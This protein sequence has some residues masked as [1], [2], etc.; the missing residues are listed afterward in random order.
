MTTRLPILNLHGWILIILM[1]AV[2]ALRFYHLPQYPYH[3]DE[4]GSLNVMM[5]IVETGKPLLESGQIYWRAL[6]AH[7]LMAL[8]LFFLEISP[9][10]ARLIPVL[11][12][13]LVLP[14]A[15]LMG[16]DAESRWTGY[17]AALFL[18]LSSYENIHSAF[19]RFYLPFQFFF[20][21]SVYFSGSFF[22]DQ[23]K[24]TGK[25]LLFTTLATIGSHKLSFQL[26]PIMIFA[27]LMGRRWR[28]ISS[29]T[30]WVSI[31]VTGVAYYLVIFFQPENIYIASMAIPLITGDMANKSFY[32]DIFKYFF[33]F[34]TTLIILGLVPLCQNRS[35]SYV[36]YYV[37]FVFSMI[38]I[39]LLSPSGS[40]RYIAQL[41][42]IGVIL[43][44][45]SLVWWLKIAPHIAKK[46]HSL[47][48]PYRLAGAALVLLL[49]GVF[50]FSM[51]R[52]SIGTAFGFPVTRD[53]QKPAHDFIYSR[54]KAGDIIIS[55]EP[56][57]TK[58]Y[59]R[60]PA[61]Y[62]IREKF[63]NKIH[64]WR[65]FTDDEKGGGTV[66][67]SPDSLLKA[68]TDAADHRVWIY[69]N[70]KHE[71]TLSS[72][73]KKTIRKHFRTVYDERE[74]YVFLKD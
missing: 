55:M 32:L 17:M 34:G 51:E 25:Y 31:V 61:D 40:A 57:L 38:V 29:K 6:V 16:K 73:I 44:M 54:L 48:A 11:F 50:L 52:K 22:I 72:E 42:P 20:L 70:Y 41:F 35:R 27:F 12:S 45:S 68:L 28:L 69:A 10:S 60:R 59:L 49:A 39:T 66:I 7:Y 33:P 13:V 58:I 19:A 15:Y 14:I 47:T 24:G 18:A 74:T 46:R 1:I 21:A 37:S 3:E 5:S 9:Y 4:I 67:D 62:A 53:D 23:K 30:F 71:F 43:S 8:P 63:D 26:L 2:F 36:Y 65:P 64:K 56:G